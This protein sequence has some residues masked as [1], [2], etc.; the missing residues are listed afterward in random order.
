MLFKFL[1]LNFINFSFC[2]PIILNED[3]DDN[4]K[5]NYN[6]ILNFYNNSDCASDF[7]SSLNF[8]H[9]CE[10]NHIITCCDEIMNIYNLTQKYNLTE[11]CSF[12]DYNNLYT[13]YQCIEIN[14]VN[15]FDLIFTIFYVIF[16]IFFLLSI[17]FCF[18]KSLD[19]KKNNDNFNGNEIEERKPIMTDIFADYR[20]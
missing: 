15:N 1:L 10:N 3:D 9:S 2:D 13:T 14:S 11:E 18:K 5:E 6:L 8:L 17:F 4:S 12:N 16:S 19:K 20:F 7:D